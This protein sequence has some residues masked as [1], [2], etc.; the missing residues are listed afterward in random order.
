MQGDHL[1]FLAI[2]AVLMISAI[3]TLVLI[4]EHGWRQ[5]ETFWFCGFKLLGVWFKCLVGST[6]TR[7]RELW[8]DDCLSGHEP[9][10]ALLADR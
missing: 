2:A 3:N 5:G 7:I 8:L 1:L 10:T 6:C 4:R 9:T